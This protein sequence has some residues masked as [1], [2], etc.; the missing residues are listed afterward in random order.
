MLQLEGAK[1]WT[2]HACPSGPLPR[3]YCWEY[4]EA[5]LGPPLMEVR[6]SV[7]DLLYSGGTTCLSLL[8]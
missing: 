2:L 1:D 4:K 3:S 5:T 7:G 8:V 6:L